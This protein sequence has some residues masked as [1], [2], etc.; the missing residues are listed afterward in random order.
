MLGCISELLVEILGEYKK[1]K[2]IRKYLTR[3][4]CTKRKRIIAWKKGDLI[5]H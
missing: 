1:N 5:R 4:L 2:Q 3:F